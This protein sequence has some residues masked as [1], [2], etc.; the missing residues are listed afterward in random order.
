MPNNDEHLKGILRRIDGRGYG[1][2]KDLSRESITFLD[3]PIAFT[4][5]FAYIQ[6][7]PFASPSKVIATISSEQSAFPDAC[8]SS[9]AR[10]IALCD[11]LT[12]RVAERAASI[13][14]RRGSGKS[15]LIAIET[16]GQKILPNT[17]TLLREDGSIELRLEVGLPARG[18]RIDGHAAIKMLCEDLPNII[19]EAIPFAIQNRTALSRH[20]EV[21]EDSVWLREQLDPRGLVAFVIDGATLPRAAGDDDGPMEGAGVVPFVS[22][23]ELRVNFTLPNAGAVEGMGIPRG[24]TA[25]VGGGYHGK[26]TLLQAISHGVYD[27]IPGD[28]REFVVTDARAV[29]VR[30]EDGRSITGV[31]ISSF[32]DGLPGDRSTRRFTSAD[33]SGSTSQAASIIEALEV[34]A[35]TLLMD[36]DTCATNFMIRDVKM[37]HLIAAG[38]EPIT[39][40]IDRV[41]TL[42]EEEGVSTVL[43][44]GGCGDYF[45][46]T[47]LVIAMRAY[48]ARDVTERA[49]EIAGDPR[50]GQGRQRLASPPP[51]SFGT[52][53]VI[54]PGSIDASKGK[55][56]VK[57]R[58]FDA[59]RASFGESELDLSGVEQIAHTAQ[60]RAILE[61][62]IWCKKQLERDATSGEGT[63]LASL[64]DALEDRISERGLLTIAGRDRG[65]LAMFRRFELAAALSRYRAL[66]LLGE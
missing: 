33:A 47:D 41:R 7:D 65:D 45:E 3:A 25:I 52:P 30:A 32:I 11:Y 46:V 40:F 39:P 15:G 22:P 37:Q 54:D 16:P 17:A 31:D 6:G 12:R 8:T 14:S 24:V 61:A 1:A 21:F 42:H 59:H 35:T 44:I 20:L 43:V 38:D 27:H 53:R 36:E 64:L 66:E 26:S 5:F 63:T 34:G 10:I 29:K 50:F 58:V 2:Y 48:S 62:M 4:L 23:P 9:E 51:A 49:H 56:A 60:T 18:R 13:R 19:A 55:R 57:T 28:G